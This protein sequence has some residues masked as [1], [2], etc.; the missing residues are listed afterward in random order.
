MKCVLQRCHEVPPKTVAIAARAL[1]G[2]GG[3]E[4]ES[5]KAPSSL[6][7]TSIDGG[8]DDTLTWAMR[9]SSRPG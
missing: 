8:G 6:V 9:P 3:H 1:V 5:Q 7:P 2:V 4:F